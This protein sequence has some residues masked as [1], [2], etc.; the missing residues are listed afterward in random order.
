MENYVGEI[1]G[2]EGVA[3]CHPTQ[4]RQTEECR[5]VAAALVLSSE[6][7]NQM[8]LRGNARAFALHRPAAIQISDLKPLNALLTCDANQQIALT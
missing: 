2:V 6:R 1:R 8:Q 7:V 4:R 3:K 5:Y